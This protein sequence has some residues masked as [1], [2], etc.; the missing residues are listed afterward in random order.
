MFR[1]KIALFLTDLRE[2]KLIFEALKGS[3]GQYSSKG[4][5]IE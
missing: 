5:T 1:G 3:V 4:E 2:I